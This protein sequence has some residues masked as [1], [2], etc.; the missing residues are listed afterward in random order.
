MNKLT[1]GQFCKIA[2]MF[3]EY[4]WDV[5]RF[6]NPDSMPPLE[7]IFAAANAIADNLTPHP[8]NLENIGQLRAL[9]AAAAEA[10]NLEKLDGAKA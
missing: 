4:G 7:S 1:A 3:P 5:V 2:R 8:H 10:G 9:A 6:I